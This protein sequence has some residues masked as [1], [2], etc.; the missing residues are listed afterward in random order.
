ML[1]LSRIRAITFDLDDTLWPIA[2]VMERA[3]RVLIDWLGEHAPMTA[4]LFANPLARHDMRQQVQ[5]DRPD[6]RHNLAAIR[7]E[8]IRRSLKK[9]GDDVSLAKPA[10]DVFFAERNRVNFYS[11]ALPA[12]RRLAR[13][14]PLVAV[15][16]GNAELERVGLTPWFKGGLAA[17]RFGAAKPDAAI[18][19]A[20]AE[21]AG[22][23]ASAVLHVG[24][25]VHLD[26]IGA[27][28]VGMQAVWINRN[29]HFLPDGCPEPHDTVTSLTELCDV[30][31]V[32][33]EQDA[34]D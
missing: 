19:M 7:L 10:F 33:A 9:A 17:G 4:A 32:P 1:N 14:Y 26:V 16:N 34:H 3:E 21:L 30:L 18:F 23:D 11:D 15:S 8:A 5:H 13:R 22:V 28:N 29:D 6:L 24:D 27:L 12:L 31:N 2:P 20:A 25:D